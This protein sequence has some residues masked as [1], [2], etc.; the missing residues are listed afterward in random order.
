M[1]RRGSKTGFV[2]AKIP[3]AWNSIVNALQPEY[4]VLKVVGALIAKIFLPE[5]V[6]HKSFILIN[7]LVAR[8]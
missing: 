1:P 4:P 6:T 2:I 3:S 7:I 5:I 8:I